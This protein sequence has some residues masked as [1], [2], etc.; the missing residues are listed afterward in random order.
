MGIKE[1]KT[2]MSQKTAKRQRK[3]AIDKAAANGA[4][5][6]D[7]AVARPPLQVPYDLAD[8][9]LGYLGTRPYAEVAKMIS[10]LMRCHPQLRKE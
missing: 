10:G 6:K 8:Q 3:A 2:T 7:T 5:P 1:P 4:P 9:I